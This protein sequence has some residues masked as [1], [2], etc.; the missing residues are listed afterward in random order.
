MPYTGI[1]LLLLH[2]SEARAEESTAASGAQQE[3]PAPVSNDSTAKWRM[4]TDQ[5]A[6]FGAQVRYIEKAEHVLMLHIIACIEE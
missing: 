1:A 4:Y 6:K 5:A 3:R 2:G